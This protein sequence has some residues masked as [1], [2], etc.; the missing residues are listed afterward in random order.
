[1]VERFVETE[2]E[3]VE[4]EAN[5][6]S[7]AVINC[8]IISRTSKCSDANRPEQNFRKLSRCGLRSERLYYT[9]DRNCGRLS[10]R[11]GV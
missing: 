11:W 4:V 3:V 6:V 8:E 10:C 1:M 2:A 9:C 7:S 5:N